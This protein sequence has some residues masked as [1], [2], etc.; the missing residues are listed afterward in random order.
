MRAEF[1]PRLSATVQVVSELRYDETY[2]P[3]VEWAYLSFDA[4]PELA[5]RVGRTSSPTFAFTDTRR[6]SYAQ[7]WVRPPAEVYDL[8]PVTN[9]DGLDVVWKTRAFGAAHTLQG[10]YGRS[11][12]I[13][14][15]ARAPR[16]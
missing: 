13:A 8:I 16:R 5:V 14:D 12:A 15:A 4:T 10:A 3:H 2:S 6:L 9:N 7:H 1:T 11:Q